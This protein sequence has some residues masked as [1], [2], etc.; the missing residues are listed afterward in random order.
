[1]PNILWIGCSLRELKTQ[2]TDKHSLRLQSCTARKHRVVIPLVP[3]PPRAHRA[4]WLEA[5]LTRARCS[6]VQARGRQE[7]RRQARAGGRG[8]RAHRQGLAAAPPG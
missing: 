7:N 8:A 6:G 3:R 5:R 1:M 2:R 4:V